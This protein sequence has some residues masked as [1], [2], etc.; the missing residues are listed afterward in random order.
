MFGL[1]FNKRYLV[2]ISFFIHLDGEER[3]G[4]ITLIVFFMSCDG[5]CSVALRYGAVSGSAVCDCCIS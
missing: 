1:C 3:I 2:P 5:K 4:C